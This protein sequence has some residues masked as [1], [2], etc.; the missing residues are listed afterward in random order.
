MIATVM[1]WVAVRWQSER[2][3]YPTPPTHKTSRTLHPRLTGT[4]RRSECR[5]PGT[6]VPTTATSVTASPPRSSCSR[7]WTHGTNWP[8]ASP[9]LRQG[10]HR[11]QCPETMR[12]SNWVPLPQAGCRWGPPGTVVEPPGTVLDRGRRTWGRGPR[13]TSP[14]P[15]W[16]RHRALLRARRHAPAA[17]LPESTPASRASTG[18][19]HA[20]SGVRPVVLWCP[21]PGSAHT[22]TR[23]K[24]FTLQKTATPAPSPR[25]PPVA[26]A[27]CSSTTP[28]CF[29]AA[30]RR[31]RA[32]PGGAT[33]VSCER[34]E[35]N[36]THSRIVTPLMPMKRPRLPPIPVDKGQ[37]R[38]ST[39][40]RRLLVV[41]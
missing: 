35:E 33:G 16:R 25:R 4:A 3:V 19:S 29:F 41:M 18:P 34:N 17:G 11:R 40:G 39:V 8:Q 5:R 20:A 21:Q 22:A 10:R 9:R 14:P 31:A 38:T 1:S 2:E 23:E 36:S 37:G 28:S 24:A 32:A 15:R 12:I 30:F 27:L 6:S 7:R 13:M 26:A